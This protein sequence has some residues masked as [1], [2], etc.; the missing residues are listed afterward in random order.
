M[1]KNIVKQKEKKIEGLTHEKAS[2]KNI[3]TADF[4]L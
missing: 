4:S 2:R 1:A 3:P